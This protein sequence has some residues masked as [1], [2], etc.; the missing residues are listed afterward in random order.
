M[1][2]D[3]WVEL[4]YVEGFGEYVGV[5]RVLASYAATS[6]MT[7]ELSHVP[8]LDSSNLGAWLRELRICFL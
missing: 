2:L 6:S 4:Q 3:R 1:D 7:E 8:E 5:W